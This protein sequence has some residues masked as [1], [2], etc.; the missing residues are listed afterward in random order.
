MIA[1]L[2]RV[3]FIQKEKSIGLKVRLFA[4]RTSQGMDWPG[5][6]DHFVALPKEDRMLRFMRRMEASDLRA[7]AAQLRSKAFAVGVAVHAGKTLAVA[8]LYAASGRPS[9][10]LGLS[11]D[12][13]A[14]RRGIGRM[15]VKR[16]I[17]LARG[18]AMT[19]V[20]A[21]MLFENIAARRLLAKCGF[22]LR[23]EG[24]ECEASTVL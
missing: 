6:V 23:C 15:L 17:G 14:R 22:S 13:S 24:E 3:P 8:E 9:A 20:R 11:V 7:Y 1:E 5:V 4:Q 10:E 19:E 2:D 12:A 16:L 18:S 21:V